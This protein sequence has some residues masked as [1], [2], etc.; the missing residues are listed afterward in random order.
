MPRRRRATPRVFGGNAA[1]AAPACGAGTVA[2]PY[3]SAQ[4]SGLLD[5]SASYFPYNASL[6]NGQSGVGGSTSYIVPHVA[7]LIVQYKKG[8]LTIS[9]SLQFQGGSRYGSPLAV[10]GVAPDTCGV[11]PGAALA[12]DPRYTNGIPGPGQPYDASSCGAVIPI[13]NPQTK[14]FDGIAEY[15]QPDLIATNLSVN[16]DFNKRVGLNLIAANIFNRCFGGSKVPWLVSNIGCAYQQAGDYVA[17]NYNPGDVI[18]PYVNQ[19]YIP[20]IGGALQSVSASSPLP[21][22]LFVNL[23]VHM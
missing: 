5:P 21:F 4:P 7:S 13:P 12:G 16:Y 15:V 19:S 9:P 11:L 17:N 20:V 23:N 2:N 1:V 6:G 14:H 22:E 8:P 18:S 3:W 10:Q